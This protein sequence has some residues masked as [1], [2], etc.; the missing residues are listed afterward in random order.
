MNKCQVCGH[1]EK[2]HIDLIWVDLTTLY[3]NYC[4]EC[5]SKQIHPF[6][7]DN[8]SFIEELAEKRGLI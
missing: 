1:H 6:Q 4:R 8:L 2:S 5:F 3:K 7:L